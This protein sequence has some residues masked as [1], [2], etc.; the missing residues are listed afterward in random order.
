MFNW[1]YYRPVILF[2]VPDNTRGKQESFP[3]TDNHVWLD[4]LV[5][6]SL[7]N[8]DDFSTS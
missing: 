3:G 5:Q 1:F 7:R 8:L 2:P 6:E 4:W